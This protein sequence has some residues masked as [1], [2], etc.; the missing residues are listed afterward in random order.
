MCQ[1]CH[2]FN[3]KKLL[4]NSWMIFKNSIFDLFSNFCWNYDEE[5][6]FDWHG[7]KLSRTKINELNWINHSKRDYR[8]ENSLHDFYKKEFIVPDNLKIK[9]SELFYRVLWESFFFALTVLNWTRI[10]STSSRRKRF[11][12]KDSI[13]F[14][15]ALA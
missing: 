15:V 3:L 9:Y 8:T 4:K 14:G 7:N 12:K 5:K 1:T 11:N 10:M 2:N 13:Y 6:I